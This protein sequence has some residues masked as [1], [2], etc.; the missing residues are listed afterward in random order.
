MAFDIPTEI[1]SALEKQKEREAEMF[2]RRTGSIELRHRPFPQ[3]RSFEIELGAKLSQHRRQKNFILGDAQGL[4]RFHH[5][6][7]APPRR[8]APG[9]SPTSA[10]E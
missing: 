8:C 4:R 3:K 1:E 6:S 7:L 2:F 10:R 5:H 9:S